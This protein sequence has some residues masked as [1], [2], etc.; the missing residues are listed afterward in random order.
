MSI[1]NE[2]HY[3]IRRKNTIS[4]KKKLNE[5]HGEDYKNYDGDNNLA[6]YTVFSICKPI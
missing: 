6:V 5:D 3:L 1:T 2:H 4:S